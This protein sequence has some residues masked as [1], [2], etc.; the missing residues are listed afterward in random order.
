MTALNGDSKNK[1]VAAAQAYFVSL[2]E[3]FAGYG[4]EH[5]ESMD[6]LTIREEISEREITLSQTAARSGVGNYASFSMAGYVGMYEMD[7]QAIRQL[8]NVS[9][10]PKRSMLDFMGKDE[11][12][13]NLFRLALTEGRIKKEGTRGQVPL[14]RVAREVG[15]RVRQTMHD[16]TG[17]YPEQLPTGQD[18]KEIRRGLKRAG[19]DFLPLDDMDAARKAEQLFLAENIPESLPDAIPGCSECAGGN[20]CPHHGSVN[21]KSGS[22]AS[23][24]SVPHC[25]CN[26]CY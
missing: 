16:E 23:G 9:D 19:K 13:G 10:K 24:G 6:R 2:A 12:A 17:V 25:N 1:N 8:R 14:E 22:I 11:L 26:F 21:C 4:I 7:Y 20:P 5:V 3:M 15:K 18:I